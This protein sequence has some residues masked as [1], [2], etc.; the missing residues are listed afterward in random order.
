[1]HVWWLLANSKIFGKVSRS[2]GQEPHTA[3][4][5][6]KNSSNAAK[7]KNYLRPTPSPVYH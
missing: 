2:G 3:L 5:Q 1:M 7:E 6:N 4:P